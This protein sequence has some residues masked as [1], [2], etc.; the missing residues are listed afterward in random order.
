MREICLEKRDGERD[1][2]FYFLS[3]SSSGSSL[4]WIGVCNWIKS[5]N[6]RCHFGS[7]KILNGN[8]EAKRYEWN[9]LYRK[10]HFQVIKNRLSI[11]RC[12]WDRYEWFFFLINYSWMSLKWNNIFLLCKTKFKYLNFLCRLRKNFKG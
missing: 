4:W 5:S 9:K 3:E 6:D 11:D 7:Y 10:V 1:A 12:K 2:L 8:G